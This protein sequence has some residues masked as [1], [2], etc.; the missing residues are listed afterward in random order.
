M[1]DKKF[2]GNVSPTYAF[3]THVA[4]VEVDTETGMV[5]VT[6]LVAVH[7]VGKVINPLLIEGQVHGGISLGLGYCLSEDLKIQAGVVQNPNFTNYHIMTAPEM[8]EIVTHYVETNDPFGPYGAKGIG[9]A[10]AIC[11]APAVANAIQ[12]ATGKRLT[13]LP[14]T[15]EKVLFALKAK[16]TD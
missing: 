5:R 11:V 8:P 3:G 6:R 1:Q 9:E 7:D 15:P 12:N 4:E 16:A 2:K 13:A 10:P 14:F